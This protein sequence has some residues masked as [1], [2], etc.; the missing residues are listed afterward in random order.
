MTRE[1]G[2]EGLVKDKINRHRHL[3]QV[4]N[5]SPSHTQNIH[6]QEISYLGNYLSNSIL[7]TCRIRFLSF[8]RLLRWCSRQGEGVGVGQNGNLCPRTLGFITC[9]RLSL[10]PSGGGGYL[11]QRF[12]SCFKGQ[13]A[14]R[15]L[16][17]L[18]M[19]ILVQNNP[20]A[21]VGYLGA[22]QGPNTSMVG[23]LFYFILFIGVTPVNK[24]IQVS[25]STIHHLY[26]MFTTQVK[27][28]ITIYPPFALFYPPPP[29]PFSLAVTILFVVC[30]H[31]SFFFLCL[32][33]S[34]FSPTL[35][36]PSRLTAV[37]FSL[38]P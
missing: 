24:I 36:N 28:F 5:D 32:N 29:Q 2:S 20:Y 16:F 23:F 17:P 4:N 8:Q 34:A 14:V 30:V 27:S 3:W 18:L 11:S 9:D 33:A 31:S 1:T 25:D 26:I 15:E 6:I 7:R 21:I 12:I 35:P 10:S 13:R 38:Y 37:R 22:A 19:L